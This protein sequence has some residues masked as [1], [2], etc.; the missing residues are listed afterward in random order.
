MD[1]K[2]RCMHPGMQGLW[3]MTFAVMSMIDYIAR[4]LT[5]TNF[6]LTIDSRVL[7]RNYIVCIVES[8]V[9]GIRLSAFCPPLGLTSYNTD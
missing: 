6:N 5:H 7:R 3:P 1:R 8:V 4:H 9:E 2:L